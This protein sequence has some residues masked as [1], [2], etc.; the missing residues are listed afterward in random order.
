M[1]TTDQ[2]IFELLRHTALLNDNKL[3]VDETRIIAKAMQTAIS[4]DEYLTLAMKDG[5]ITSD[6]LG[7]L[8][9]LLDKIYEEAERAAK[10]DDI[11]SPEEADLL[12]KLSNFILALKSS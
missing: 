6:E 5:V 3:S 11:I 9:S 7:K 1:P 2:E 12:S 10:R 4:Y 8:H